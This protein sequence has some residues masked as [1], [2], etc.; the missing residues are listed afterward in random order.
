MATTAGKRASAK[1]KTDGKRRVQS[2]FPKVPL[3]DAVRIASAIEEANGGSPYPPNDTAFAL[4][5]SPGSSHWRTL[6]A[7]SFKYGLTTGTYKSERLEITVLGQRITAPT[8]SEDREAAL[9]ESALAPSTFRSIFDR[10]KSKKIPA[11]EFFENTVV[12]DFGLPREHAAQCVEV[13][14]K[15]AQFLNLTRTARDGQW[16]GAEPS[17]ISI[18]APSRPESDL[19]EADEP[20]V[21]VDDRDDSL[22]SLT[23]QTSPLRSGDPS[24]EG[25]GREIFIGHG[26][27]HK[28][29]TQLQKILNEYGIPHQIAVDEANEG[30]PISQKVAQVMRECGAAILIFTADEEFRSPAGDEIWRPSEN[31]VYEL[32]AASVLYGQRIIIFKESGVTF[33]TNFQDIGYIPFEQDDLA[34]KGIDLFRELIA[35][36]LI[37][38]SVST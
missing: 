24:T 4:N 31:V 15:N 34:A 3:E 25:R 21:Y 8:S 33:P 19:D 7:A 9:F 28:P 32:G 36:K 18:D 20:A 5:L 29:L 10:F 2:D 17:G 30:R 38:V 37:Q 27:S 16:L 6:T 35:A 23:F 11:K 26:K 1:P 12:R 22:E 14:I 13:F